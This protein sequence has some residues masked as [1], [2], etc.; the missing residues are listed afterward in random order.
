MTSTIFWSFGPPFLYLSPHRLELVQPPLQPADW[1]PPPLSA[2]VIKV[3][4]LELCE[5]CGESFSDYSW[6][7]EL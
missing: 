3:S 5:G 7:Y 1:S 2:D 4:H 6:I